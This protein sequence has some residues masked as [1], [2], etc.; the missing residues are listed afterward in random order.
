MEEQEIGIIY[1]KTERLSLLILLVSLPLFGVVY[2]YQ[3]SG[4]LYWD[5]PKL[6][7]FINGFFIGFSIAGLTAQYVIFHKKVKLSFAE[8]D[9]IEKVRIYLNATAQ[10]FWILFFVSIFSTVGLLFNQNP[11]YVLVFAVTL[12]FFSLAKP[13][14]D[15]MARL[16]KL[17][18][19]DRELIRD[20]SR[21]QIN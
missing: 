7:G 9:L 20:A 13:T 5:L 15:R 3:N 17:K 11:I 8:T 10:R 1:R 19:E 12:L 16:M 21:P 4:N 2:L 6:P 14:P 18:K